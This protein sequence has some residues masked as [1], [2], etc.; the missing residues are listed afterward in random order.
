MERYLISDS[1]TKVFIVNSPVDTVT[2]QSLEA[3]DNQLPWDCRSLTESRDPFIK[4][5][6]SVLSQY[7]GDEVQQCICRDSEVLVA[8]ILDCTAV[9][10]NLRE[11]QREDFL[12]KFESVARGLSFAYGET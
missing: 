1:K 4:T 6:K 8:L 11:I 12:S 9:E 5:I 2:C 3:S 10:L 7:L